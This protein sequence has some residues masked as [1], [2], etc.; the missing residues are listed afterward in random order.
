MNEI[1]RNFN[2]FMNSLNGIKIYSISGDDEFNKKPF[3]NLLDEHDIKHYFFVSSQIHIV[4]HSDPL[5]IID[6][7]CRTYKSLMNKYLFNINSNDWI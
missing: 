4:R 2:L 3:I 7:W 1:I 5:G 6:R